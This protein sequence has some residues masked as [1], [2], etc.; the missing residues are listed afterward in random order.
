MRDETDARL[1]KAARFA[2]SALAD[3]IEALKEQV[4]KFEREIVAE[5]NETSVWTTGYDIGC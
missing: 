5:A 1:P 3:Q 2:L 4:D